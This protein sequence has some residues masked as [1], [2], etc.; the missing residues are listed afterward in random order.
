MGVKRIMAYDDEVEICKASFAVAPAIVGA[1]DLVLRLPLPSAPPPPQKQAQKW[2]RLQPFAKTT[3]LPRDLLF[4]QE[5][6]SEFLELLELQRQRHCMYATALK[7]HRTLIAEIQLQLKGMA[8]DPRA[9]PGGG[10]PDVG[11]RSTASAPSLRARESEVIAENAGGNVKVVVRVRGFLPRGMN[12]I[13]T[14]H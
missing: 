7:R 10:S 6:R 14:Q 8:L 4:T 9:F 11:Y 5:L 2:L 12:A 1:E 13:Y 3:E